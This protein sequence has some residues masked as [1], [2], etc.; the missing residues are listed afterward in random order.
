MKIWQKILAAMLALLC[1]ALPACAE[2]DDMEDL[3]YWYEQLY[4]LSE[5]IGMRYVGYEGE[6]AAMDYVR[7]TSKGSWL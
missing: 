5:E 2:F 7:A 6:L 4:M 3:D 1:T